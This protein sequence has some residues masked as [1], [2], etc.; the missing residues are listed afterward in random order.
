MQ[1]DIR[2]VYTIVLEAWTKP[3][4]ALM[5]PLA[6]FHLDDHQAVACLEAE[7]SVVLLEQLYDECL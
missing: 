6:G 1:Y 5:L 4:I 2:S 3:S 7:T